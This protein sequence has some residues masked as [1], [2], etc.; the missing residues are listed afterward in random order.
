VP[1][2]VAA[3]VVEAATVV[4]AAAVEV[5]AAVDPAAVLLPTAVVPAIVVPPSVLDPAAVDAADVADTDPA[6]VVAAADVL[7]ADVA[8]KVVLPPV[9]V[10]SPVEIVD[11]IGEAVKVEAAADVEPAIVELGVVAV[12]AVLGFWAAVESLVIVEDAAAPIVVALLPPVPQS[13][14][15]V[16][17]LNVVAIEQIFVSTI[18]CLHHCAQNT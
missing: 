7:P 11:D 15:D 3:A 5:A 9:T 2:V 13:T 18:V 14:V 6:E 12:A 1:V 4:E 17:M 8:D 16:E 10:E